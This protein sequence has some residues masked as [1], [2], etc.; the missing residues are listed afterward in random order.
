MVKSGS[1]APHTEERSSQGGADDTSLVRSRH[2]IHD[3]GRTVVL[4]LG[5]RRSGCHPGNQHVGSHADREWPQ[6]PARIHVDP[7][8]TLYAALS[9]ADT[10]GAT[11]LA[12][13]ASEDGHF[14]GGLNG[15]VS[16]IDDNGSGVVFQGTLP[17]AGGTG[18]PYLGPSDI[19]I[20]N[21]QIYVLD[22]G[23]GASHGIPLTPDG[24]YA[25]DGGGSARLVADNGSWVRANP[26][27][28]P[29]ETLV[30]T[31]T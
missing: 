11:A 29:R 28:N 19:A 6:Q 27:V 26:V 3:I 14:V 31:A 22:D 8:G 18:G 5:D 12:T 1:N 9:T 25:I 7:D 20:L 15:N 2:S 21:G 16:R 13:P 24:A 4:R 17:S 30:L 10:H 23:G